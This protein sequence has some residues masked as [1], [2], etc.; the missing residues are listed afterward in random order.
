MAKGVVVLRRG[1]ERSV[2]LG[3]PWLLSGSVLRVEGAPA[4]G[5]TVAVHDEAGAVLGFGDFDPDAQL[6][7]RITSFGKDEPDEAAWLEAR[8]QTAVAR[9]R[10]HPLLAGTDAVRLVHAEADG[11]PGLVVDRY[12]DF[13][14][15]RVGTPGMA[16]RAALAGELVRRITGAQAAWLR[17]DGAPGRELFGSVPDAPIGIS[18]SERSYLVDLKHG[19]KT[20]FYLDQRDARDLFARL[21]RGAR[22]LDLFAHTGGFARAALAGGARH[23]TAVESSREALALAQQNAAGAELV[24]ADVNEYLR[25]ERASFDLISVDPPPFAKKKR[26]VPAASRAYKDLNLRVFARAAAG[27]HV[28]TFSCSHHVEPELFR[29]L[30]FAAALDAR[31]EVQVLGELRAPIDHPVSIRHP[32]GEY[33]KGLLLRV[34]GDA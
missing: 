4:P 28:L 33:L 22:A 25:R 12:G 32:Q 31:R 6:R 9:R 18:E 5:D 14:A 30:V 26:D 21:A 7:V 2:A 3:H 1:R 10:G 29:K 17:S 24:A 8:L 16:R 15:L 13:L 19:Q 34:G 23:V 20:G 27:A 11:L